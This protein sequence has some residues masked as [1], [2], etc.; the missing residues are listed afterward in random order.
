MMKD[1]K[2]SLFLLLLLQIG[3]TTKFSKE[4]DR[5]PNTAS[6][7]QFVSS[8][9]GFS[10]PVRIELPN[11]ANEAGVERVIIFVHGS[12]P[13]NADGDL[14]SVSIPAEIPNLVYKDLATA[15]RD[16]GFATVRYNKRSF[17]AREALK[18]NVDYSKSAQFK[19][20]SQRPLQYFLDDLKTISQKTKD[21]FPNAKIYILGHSEGSNLALWAASQ[22][23]RKMVAGVALVGFGNEKQSS[24][25]YEQIVYRSYFSF[26]RQLDKNGDL[27]I[28]KSEL[29]VNSDLAKG[30]RSQLPT[31]DLDK[32][33]IVDLSEYNAGNYSNTIVY[34]G[35]YDLGYQ[36]TESSLPRPSEVIQKAEFK[37]LFLQGELD[38]QT[39]AFHAKAVEISN[40]A[41]WKKENLKFVYFPGKGH[42]L[43]QRTSMADTAFRKVESAVLKKVSSEMDEF[44]R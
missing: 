42:A 6:E 17:E 13:Q 24:L 30:L 2:K 26:F 11:G 5:S 43:D 32:N 8:F 22:M 35:F 1:F 36:I 7:I 40:R 29:K 37:I 4:S 16:K 21:L 27:E 3:C 10:L 19:A 23:Q 38:N 12:G 28:D 33:G 20:Y 39:P 34:P 44:F 15:L 9:D 41:L 18:K 31:L 25:I 14:T